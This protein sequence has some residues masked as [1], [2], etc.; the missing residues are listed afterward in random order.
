MLAE[1]PNLRAAIR[2][3]LASDDGALAA[4]LVIG[5]ATV[6]LSVGP[7][8]ELAGWLERLLRR[9]DLSTGRRVDA[10]YATAYLRER[11]GDLAGV[12]ELLGR[13]GRLAMRIEDDGRLAWVVSFQAWHAVLAG[14]EMRVGELVAR[15]TALSESHPE[16]L[17]LGARTLMLHGLACPDASQAVARLEEGLRFTRVSML[18]VTSLGLLANLAEKT[19]R[20]GEPRRALRLADEG[21][22]LATVLGAAENVGVLLALRAY[23]LLLLGYVA[24]SRRDALAGVHHAVALG[25]V[26]FGRHAVVFLAAGTAQDDPGRAAQ[27]LGIA[28]AGRPD[29][30]HSAVDHAVDRFLADLPGRMGA[31]YAP[32]H[33]AGR[34]LV[35][36]RGMLGALQSVLDGADDEPAGVR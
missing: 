8:D 25:N 30:D 20:L 33:D 5:V 18:D 3:A 11:V 36:E 29:V 27:L 10:L 23:A 1:R 19:L 16:D 6:W 4:D 7:R 35:S 28:D 34:Q 14:D 2:W 21:I 22:P 15:T 12:A 26:V 31:G 32:A 13:A 9:D 24:E 17:E